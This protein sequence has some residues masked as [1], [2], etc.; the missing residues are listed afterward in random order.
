MSKRSE[1]KKV[2]KRERDSGR[3]LSTKKARRRKQSP[4]ALRARARFPRASTRPALVSLSLSLSLSRKRRRDKK[5]NPIQKSLSSTHLDALRVRPD[6][7]GRRIRRDDF[8]RG[9]DDHRRRGGGDSLFLYRLVSERDGR[10]RGD[11][12]A[13]LHFECRCALFLCGE[14]ERGR[15]KERGTR[16]GRKERNERCS[17]FTKQRRGGGLCPPPFWSSRLP[18][19]LSVCVCWS[20]SSREN[21]ES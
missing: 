17:N 9:T 20:S 7:F 13:S 15:G 12:L 14:R 18:I 2:P 16:V 19:S 3:A 1:K 21:N 4:V 11:G 5:R 10:A 6:R 8:L